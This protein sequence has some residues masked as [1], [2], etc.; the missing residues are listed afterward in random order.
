MLVKYIRAFTLIELIVTLSV[1]AILAAITVPG[2]SAM[3][4]DNRLLT[5]ANSLV[6][7]IQL[8]RSEAIKQGVQ[9]TIKKNG[10][11]S[12]NW[13]S[14]WYVFTDWD[15]DG[16][17]D[18]NGTAPACETEEDCLLRTYEDIPSNYTL[19]TGNNF[20]TWLGFLPTG[21]PVSS[22]GDGSG[23]FRLCASDSDTTNARTISLNATGHP[24]IDTGALACP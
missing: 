2:F 14:G 20:S 5:Q 6:S 19:R 22:A 11:T 13:D 3:I 12:S 16:Q 7:S 10:S 17:Y 23:S 1:A 21:F 4:R 18:D 9:V 15:G 24:S 8:A